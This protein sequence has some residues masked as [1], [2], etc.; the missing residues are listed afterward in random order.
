[1]I[2]CLISISVCLAACSPAPRDVS[3]FE[4]NPEAAR[5]ILA[6]CATGTSETECENART[7]LNR[8]K[9]SARKERYR[10]GFE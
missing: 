10:K 4:A 9:A 6:R 3:W 5:K 1:M 2:R 7:A 8:V